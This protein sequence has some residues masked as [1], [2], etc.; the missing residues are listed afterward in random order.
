M[1]SIR[2][3]LL[4]YM[5]ENS[6]HQLASI[7]IEKALKDLDPQVETLIV[8]SLDY[9]NPRLD[10]VVSNVYLSMLRRTP[11]IWDYLYDNPKVVRG[12]N[13]TTRV[14]NRLSSVRMERLIDS[15]SP[16]TIVCTQAFP[17]GVMATYKERRRVNIP[18]IGVVTD[19]MAHAYWLYEGVNLYAVPSEVSREDLVERGIEERRIR[20]TGI[21]IHPKFRQEQDRNELREKLNLSPC[22]PTILI[23]GGG[24]G[25]GPLRETIRC[26]D[27]LDCRFQMVVVSGMNKALEK[28]LRKEKVRMKKPIH[29]F[30]YAG[31][32]D[33]LMEA[34]DII[35]TKPGGMTTAEALAKGLAMVILCPLPGQEERNGHFL[36]GRGIAQRAD[37][38]VEAAQIVSDLL[39][40]SAKLAWLRSKARDWARPDASFEIVRLALNGSGC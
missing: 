7:A 15:F 33:E 17:C 32:V 22:L 1:M 28:R 12:T 2:R 4:L 38:A 18:L 37:D 16:D 24:Q 6:G 8:N 14:I 35:I 11:R 20:V 21:P 40:D 9:I 36:T 25:F 31:N 5:F 19:Y 23:M 26:L 10:R 13:G 39:R 27:E 29:V 3:V 30:G 34:S